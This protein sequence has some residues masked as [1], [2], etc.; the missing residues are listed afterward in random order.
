M[1]NLSDK[2]LDQMVAK[3]R[4]WAEE[5]DGIS[6]WYFKDEATRDDPAQ[7]KKMITNY[8]PTF[9]WEQ[10]GQMMEE[11]KISLQVSSNNASKTLWSAQIETETQRQFASATDANPKRAVCLAFIESKEIK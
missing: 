10:C 6:K 3:A 2:E 11:F 8:H 5:T 9:N 4:G 1:N 7:W